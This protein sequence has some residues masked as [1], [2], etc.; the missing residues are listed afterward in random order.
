MRKKIA[1]EFQEGFREKCDGNRERNF[2]SRGRRREKK[3]ER[4]KRRKE[5]NW[6]KSK[7]VTDSIRQIFLWF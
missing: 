5:K 7:R 6:R 3:K 2:F 4:I 1:K